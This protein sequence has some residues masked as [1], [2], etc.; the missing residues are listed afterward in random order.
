[1]ALTDRLTAIGNAI[2]EKNG[3]TE[4][5]PLVDMPQAILD[6]VS[7]GGDSTNE[8]IESTGTQYIDTGI[9]VKTGYKVVIDF[10]L[11][12]EQRN[13]A[14]FGVVNGNNWEN[15]FQCVIIDEFDERF[16]FDVSQKSLLERTTAYGL[17]TRDYTNTAYLF[18]RNWEGFEDC[19]AMRLFNFTITNEKSE[20]IQWL[21]PAIDKDGVICLYDKVTKTYFYNQGTGEFIGVASEIVEP[22]EEQ[23][24]TVTITENGTTEVLPDENKALSKVTVI[25]EVEGDG[26]TEEIE[27][28]IDNSGVLD[29]TE[30]SVSD[31]VEQLI[32]LVEENTLPDWDDDSPIIASGYGYYTCVVWEITEK[33]TMR[34]KYVPDGT[35]AGVY[36]TTAGWSN[37]I[38]AASQNKEYM[39]YASKVRQIDIGE[40]LINVYLGYAINCERIRI[41]EDLTNINL[42]SF[43]SLKELI[44][45]E[46]VLEKIKYGNGFYSIEKINIPN[47]NTTIPANYAKLC[48]FL[49]EV[50]IEHITSFGS[51]CFEEC[52][53]LEK[54]IVF[55]PD[56]TSIGSKAFS[57]SGI[58]TVR[59]QNSTDNLPT[60]STNVFSQCN[61]LTDIYCPWE[62]GAVANAPW[63]APAT[64]NIHYNYVEGEETNADS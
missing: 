23:E 9:V 54:D 58:K 37:T 60:V 1:M 61:N 18:G 29:S 13:K 32:D 63:G 26:G 55:N 14:V 10:Q 7:G 56:L 34:W 45:S 2:R 5:I 4:L 50:N 22:K 36:A 39:K 30:G 41:K 17:A 19:V 12:K 57:R 25:T 11:T 21:I 35:G 38:N 8:Y 46:K 53:N 28:L 27:D 3:T 33:G 47:T 40:K 52:V 64:V 20:L 51:S 24:K 49:K 42:V 44:C 43:T 31:K 48:Y 59:F 62:E 6:I 16:G 15:A